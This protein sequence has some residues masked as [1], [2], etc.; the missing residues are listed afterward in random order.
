MVFSINARFCAKMLH[1]LLRI[2]SKLTCIT[3]GQ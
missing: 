2:E 3:Y 1:K